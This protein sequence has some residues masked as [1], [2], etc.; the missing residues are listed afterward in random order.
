MFRNI[1]IL[2]KGLLSYGDKWLYASGMNVKNNSKDIS[3]I[4]EE[5]QDLK[6]LVKFG[7][8]TILLNH[9]GDY[10]NKSAIHTPYLSKI[11]K[12]KLNTKVYY[13]K[14]IDKSLIKK[15]NTKLK[16]GEIAILGNTRLFSGEQKNSLNLSKFF[17]KFADQIVIGGFCKIHRKN[18][19]NYGILNFIDGYLSNGVLNEV[20][21]IERWKKKSKNKIAIIGG[22][23]KEKVINGIGFLANKYD[24]VLPTGVFLN[25]IIKSIGFE[26]GLSKILNNKILEKNLLN[27][28]KTNNFKNKFILPEKV[29]VCK[30]KSKKIL[31]R[32]TEKVEKDEIICGIKITKKIHNLF[33]ELRKRRFSFLIAGTPDY[34]EKGIR[35]MGEFLK[36]FIKKNNLNY[37]ILGG[38]TARD[39]SIKKNTSSGGGASL[40]FLAGK[41]LPILN[42]LKQN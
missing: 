26:I 15:I 9:Q 39:L 42:K 7:V 38:D 31:Y 23:K 37:L 14:K 1:K 36:K 30:K 32:D 4:N 17:S 40:E 24:Y 6:L 25:M 27:F 22:T 33:F 8:K 19:S 21:K 10:D 28:V 41:K 20:K 12:K 2:N 11:L 13:Y 5:I 34:K 3:R 18:S 29:I 35:K 16:P